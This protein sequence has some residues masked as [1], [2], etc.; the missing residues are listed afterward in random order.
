MKKLFILSLAVF[1][2]LSLLTS[3]GEKGTGNATENTTKECC[4]S[5]KNCT[6]NVA[7]TLTK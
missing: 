5:T 1:T 4:D 3:C 6:T 7:D 2:S